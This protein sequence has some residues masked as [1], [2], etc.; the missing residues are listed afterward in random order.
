MHSHSGEFCTHAEGSLESVVQSALARGFSAIGLSEHMP[1]DRPQHLYPDELEAGLDVPALHSRFGGYV[2]EAR[3]LQREYAHRIAVLV[4]GETEWIDD[5]SVQTMRAWADDLDYLV[6][7]VH[8][9]MGFPIDDEDGYARAEAAAAAG[10]GGLKEEEEEAAPTELVFRRYF[11]DQHAMLLALRPAVVGHFDLCRAL[12]PAHPLSQACWAR[13]DRNARCI[14]NYGG[15]VE[16]NTAALLSDGLVDPYPQRDIAKRLSELGVRFTLSDDSH[17]PF[18]VGLNY[19]ALRTYL[20]VELG[21][22]EVF[23]LLPALDD[24]DDD[25]GKDS[26]APAAAAATAAG[27]L[28][29]TTR[30]ARTAV[31]R[32]A[33]VLRDRFWRT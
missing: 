15:L 10:G 8:H 21:V 23:C 27:T 14:A 26:A 3:R 19:G 5:G 20:E 2:A 16:I 12:R 7:S 22:R 17:G 31:R 25:Y 32:Q 29:T 24:D 28:T 18:A 4:G 9:C 30:T 1:R 6:G 11:D 13:I 33:H